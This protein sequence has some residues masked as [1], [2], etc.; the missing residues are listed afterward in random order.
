[1]VMQSS[2]AHAFRLA[3]VSILSIQLSCALRGNQDVQAM[4]LRTNS[5]VGT[6]TNFEATISDCGIYVGDKQTVCSLNADTKG[7]TFSFESGSWTTLR[8][9]GDCKKSITGGS[10]TMSVNVGP[11]SLTVTPPGGD[12][13]KEVVQSISRSPL[14]EFGK[15]KW[16]G[17]CAEGCVAGHLPVNVEVNMNKLGYLMRAFAVAPTDIKVE[18]HDAQ[19]NQLLCVSV[20]A[21]VL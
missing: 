15:F 12:I 14:G 10:Y 11:A 2:S 4:N 20:S 7:A 6:G 1:M 19:S 16:P 13:T 5:S 8:V 21:K 17:V 3:L 9:G 18:A